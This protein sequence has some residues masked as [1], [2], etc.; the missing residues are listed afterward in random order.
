[1]D[2]TAVSKTAILTLIYRVIE[3]EKKNSIFKDPMAVFCLNELLQY[4][5]EDEKII[6]AKF[7]KKYSVMPRYG[8]VKSGVQRAMAID[9]IVNEYIAKNPHCTVVN[10]ACGFDTRFWRINNKECNYIELD[11][12]E[13][14]TLKKKILKDA[15]EFEMIG[16]SVLDTSWIDKVTLNHNDKFLLIAEGLLCYLSKEAATSLLQNLSRR[17]VDSQFTFDAIYRIFTRGL[18]RKLAN[19]SFKHYL[20]ADTT[21]LFGFGKPEEIEA[22]GTGYKLI[23]TKT[24]KGKA[25]S[26]IINASINAEGVVWHR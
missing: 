6:Y 11:L 18:F 13:V 9:G 10:L 20:G 17:F 21:W 16:G 2:L 1:M 24:T 12:P 4:A 5:S 23:N 26:M 14:I 7:K 8:D 19:W 22:Y 15:A 3:T 25:V